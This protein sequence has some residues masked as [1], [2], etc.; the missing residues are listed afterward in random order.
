MFDLLRHAGWAVVR[1]GEVMEFGRP[2]DH[3]WNR[4]TPSF[5]YGS[6]RSSD[7]E[8]PRADGRGVGI[9]YMAGS[10]IAFDLVVS[11][12][13][14]VLRERVEA[15]RRHW[16]A[17][18]ER[19][20]P[21]GVVELQMRYDGRSRSVFGR[22]RRWSPDY[23]AASTSGLVA[24]QADFECIDDL[25]YGPERSVAV[26]LAASGGSGFVAPFIFPLSSTATS[27]RSVTLTV[28]GSADTWPVFTVRGPVTNPVLQVGSVRI[29]VRASVAFD[30]SVVV[31]TRPWV[32]SVTRGGL[33]LAGALRGTRLA[34]AA[35][36]PGTH[37]ITVSGVDASGTGSVSV[38][39]RDAYL[40]P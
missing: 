38:A 5:G 34:A 18:A 21:G 4:T 8:R 29:E 40:A 10:T 25:F 32:R 23:S 26:T 31:D 30:E 17:D 7:F 13:G 16:R 6:V 12:S 35:L 2:D 11:G 9:D 36:A 24:I 20:V 28:D 3:V 15:L 1:A 14:A 27:D 33:S 19:A 22:P 39:W 37:D